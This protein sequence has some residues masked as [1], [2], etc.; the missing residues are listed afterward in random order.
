MRSLTFSQGGGR[1]KKFSGNPPADEAS[2]RAGS[3]Y[4][5][6]PVEYAA[7]LRIANGGEG[8]V[9][10]A[11]VILWPVEQPRRRRSR[12]EWCQPA[13]TARAGARRWRRGRAR[14]RLVGA[15]VLTCP[16]T[17]VSPGRRRPHADMSVLYQAW[18]RSIRTLCRVPRI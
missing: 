2:I 3:D 9:G 4:L 12:A 18:V 17:G 14:S 16:T 13:P 6:L 15:M 8:F 5:H 7:F 1:L 10:H 11:Y